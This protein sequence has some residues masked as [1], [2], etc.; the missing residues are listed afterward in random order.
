MNLGM[1]PVK[2]IEAHGQLSHL[3]MLIS[4]TSKGLLVAAPHSQAYFDA[5]QELKALFSAEAQ[6]VKD[7]EQ[8]I[9]SER[10]A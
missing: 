4:N 7:L 5:H 3:R 6:A 1:I 10:E 2:T 8:A 9:E